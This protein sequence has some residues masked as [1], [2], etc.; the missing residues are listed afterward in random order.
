MTTSPL[1]AAPSR[2]GATHRPGWPEIGV[3]AAVYVVVFLVAP[4]PILQATEDSAIARGLALAA[5]SGVMGLAAFFGAYALRL[6]SWSAF[7]VRRISG[8]WVLISVG[9]GLVA[10]LVTRLVVLVVVAITGGLAGDPQGD[11]RSAAAGGALA[12]T[13]QLLFIA[14]LTPI[15]EEFAFRGVLT[16]ALGRYGVWISVVVSTLVFALAHGIN[17]ALAPA[18][19]VGLISA[20]LFVRTRSVWPGVIVHGVNNGLGTLLPVLLGLTA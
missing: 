8:R 12:L 14:V 6:R 13:L 17:L 4:G 5:L 20:L 3:A 10:L 11:Y 15:G 1:P 18:V 16:N 7:G 9:L 2:V 19:V